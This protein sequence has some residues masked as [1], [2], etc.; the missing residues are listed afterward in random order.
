MPWCQV[1]LANC[2][3]SLLAERIWRDRRIEVLRSSLLDRRQRGPQGVA[4]IDKKGRAGDVV[5]VR[6]AEK[7]GGMA[8]IGRGAQAAPRKTRSGPGDRVVTEFQ[9]FARRVDPARLDH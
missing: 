1:R 5:G 2:A 9:M 4:A 6:R 8:D 7:D 3:S